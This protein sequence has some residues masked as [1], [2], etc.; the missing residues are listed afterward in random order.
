MPRKVST[1]SP[2]RSPSPKRQASPKRSPKREAPVVKVVET[3]D[4][5]TAVATA[6]AEVIAGGPEG[7]NV[8]LINQQKKDER[9][10]LA[11]GETNWFEIFT[12]LSFIIRLL[13][14]VAVMTV[15]ALIILN[16]TL[17][18]DSKSWYNQIYKLDW[19]PDGITVVVIFAFLSFLFAWC[20]FR[21][22]QMCNPVYVNVVFLLILGLQFTYTLCLYRAQ[23][24]EAGRYLI[25]FYLGFVSL[26]FLFSLWYFGFSDVSLYLFLYVGW[27]I[28]VLLYTFGMK[29]LDKE[30]K[31][32]GLV[33]DKKSSLYKKK[34]KMEVVE[35][36]KVDEN[37]IKTEFNPLEQE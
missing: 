8:Q 13:V 10:K 15:C 26:L 4:T 14:V 7:Q 17:N 27:L 16:T 19:A 11:P 18:P 23:S 24:L 12:S 3:K 25:S 20:W 36:I 28:L 29:E 22:A 34:M 2:K 33:K 35:G 31:I 30:Y 21:F 37:G 5:I 32:L 6:A 9:M 1:S